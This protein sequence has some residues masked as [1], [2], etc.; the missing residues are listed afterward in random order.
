MQNMASKFIHRYPALSYRDFRLLWFS[1]L[2][3]ASG[4]QMQIVA[5]NWQIYLLTHSAL[6]LGLLGLMRVVPI[7]IFSLIGGSVADVFNRKKVLLLCQTSLTI[8]SAVLAVATFTHT[9]S[10]YLIYGVIVLS[11]VAMAF[12]MPA[13][14]ALL[15]NLVDRKH[16]TNALSLNAILRQV[17]SIGG[18]AIGGL[19]IGHFNIGSVYALNAVTFLAVIMAL[20]FMKTSGLAINDTPSTISWESVKEGLQFVI[21]KKL[22]WSTMILDFF[23]TFFASATALLPIFAQD[24]LHVGPEGLGMLYSADSI[25]ALIAGGVVASIEKVG[26]QGKILLVSI[27]AY[28]V[29]TIMF[30]LSKN[31]YLSILALAIVGAGD[32]ISTIIRNTIRQIATPD[33]IRGRMT[34]I[35]MIFFMGGPQLGEFEAGV[36]ASLIGAPLSVMT[37]GIGTLVVVCVVAF[38]IPVLRRYNTHESHSLL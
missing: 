32:S 35:N 17:A 12:N 7:V 25:G 20:L 36:M 8:L 33:Y 38:T 27:A 3:S 6:A 5:V 9:V 19:I 21:S 26:K 30:G 18:P 13:Q 14:Q 29:G 1:Q 31:Y 10:S 37:G 22:I 15:P 2:I 16:L 11:A 34:A 23:S 24:I 28:A 4:S